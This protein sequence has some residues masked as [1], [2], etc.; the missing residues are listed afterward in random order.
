MSQQLLL[1]SMNKLNDKQEQYPPYSSK[2]W[3][4]KHFS[5]YCCDAFPSGI[6]DKY[7]SENQIHTQV[8]KKQEG[9]FVFTRL[10]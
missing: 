9:E 7:L 8:D 5:D 3:F 1:L 6:P 4:C 10:P 2:C